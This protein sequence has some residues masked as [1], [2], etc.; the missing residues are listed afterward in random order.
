MFKSFDDNQYDCESS[1]HLQVEGLSWGCRERQVLHDVGFTVNHG[2]FVGLLGPNGVGKSTL[3]RCLYRYLIP[4][5]GRIALAG[6]EIGT[7]S[8]RA[9]AR[10]VAVVTQHGPSGFSM[11]V[12]QFLTT[13]LLAHSSWW[14][15]LDRRDESARVEAVLQRVK[16]A[17]L[18][19]HHFDSLSGGERQRVLIARALLQQPRLLLLD[20]PTNHLDVRYQIETL[21][22]VRSLGITVV[23]S[24]HDLNLA[25]AY[26]DR[27]LLLSEGALVASGLPQQVLT[28][29]RIRSVYGV[30]ARVDMHPNGRYPRIT[31]DYQKPAYALA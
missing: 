3:L 11:T 10:Q 13:G 24:I 7:I 27:I 8:R 20:E 5:Q 31:Y 16:L 26:C 2:E 6:T 4:Q 12:R 15:R 14:Q 9:F 29:D 22:L 17:S 19:E 18:A 28:A 25:S 21:K 30:D 1:P 23:A